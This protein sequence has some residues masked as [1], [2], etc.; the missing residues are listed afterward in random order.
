M[1]RKISPETSPP[2]P[3]TGMLRDLHGI[4][5][6]GRK[7]FAFFIFFCNCVAEKNENLNNFMA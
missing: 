4:E 1:N 3:A 5:R 6:G 2:A 7:E